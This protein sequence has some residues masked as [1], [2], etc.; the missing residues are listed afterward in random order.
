MGRFVNPGNEGFTRVVADDYVDKTGLVSLF[1]TTL[2]TAKRLVMV[3][4]LPSLRQELRRQV[5]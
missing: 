5:A 3:R 2:G 4:L 1:D